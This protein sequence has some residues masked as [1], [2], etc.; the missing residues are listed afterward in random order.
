MRV[1]KLV[2]VT[3]QIF[4]NETNIYKCSIFPHVVCIY[5]LAEVKSCIWASLMPGLTACGDSTYVVQ[6]LMKNVRQLI[7]LCIPPF[8]LHVY[9]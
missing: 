9:Y 1:R 3:K 6:M 2:V 8:I 5:S 7:H 4:R